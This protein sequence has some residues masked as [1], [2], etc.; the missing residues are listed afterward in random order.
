MSN[1]ISVLDELPPSEKSV[2]FYWENSYGLSRL[3]KGYYAKK[4]EVEYDNEEFEEFMDYSEEKDQYFVK[5][6]W[7][8]N[9]WELEY[10]AKIENVT[11]W[12]LLPDLPKATLQDSIN[13]YNSW[14]N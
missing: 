11:H 4:H 2:L 1:W 7:Y 3:S 14:I 10:T 8:E 6:G 12:H 13:L 9:G 5:E